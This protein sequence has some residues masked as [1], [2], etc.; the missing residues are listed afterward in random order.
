MHGDSYICPIK[1][2]R[3]HITPSATRRALYVVSSILYGQ[4]YESACIIWYIIPDRKICITNKTPEH[5]NFQIDALTGS[6]KQIRFDGFSSSSMQLVY[7]L[8][9]DFLFF[10]ET[11]WA[12]PP[13]KRRAYQRSPSSLITFSRFFYFWRHMTDKSPDK[14]H[15]LYQMKHIS[16]CKQT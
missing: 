15:P 8:S 12:Q 13:Q 2:F 1:C 16:D 11:R 7:V 3:Q 14:S 4:I 5:K 6:S 10:I 9:V